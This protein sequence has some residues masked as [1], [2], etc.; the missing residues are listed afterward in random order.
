MMNPTLRHELQTP[1]VAFS[2]VGVIMFILHALKRGRAA[3]LLAHATLILAS[4][5]LAI[6]LWE[7][8]KRKEQEWGW[9]G[10]A[11]SLRKPSSHFWRGFLTHLP[12]FLIASYLTYRWWA[13]NPRT[14][15]N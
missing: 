3:G 13:R 2:T 10:L 4:G 1:T 5:G 12:Q 6:A 15:E 8:T 9:V 14:E 7:E 11:R